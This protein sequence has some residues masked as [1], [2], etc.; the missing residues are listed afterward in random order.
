MA[1]TSRFVKFVSRPRMNPA[2]LGSLR[3]WTLPGTFFKLGI[4]RESQKKRHANTPPDLVA[5]HVRAA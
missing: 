2:L 5:R 1:H 4:A 3:K